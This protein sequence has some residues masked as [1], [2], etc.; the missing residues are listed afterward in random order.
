MDSLTLLEQARS[1]GLV[2]MVRNDKLVVRGPRQ[3]GAL[4]EQLLSHKTEV[5]NALALEALRPADLP[6]DWPFLWDDR[7]AIMEFDGGLHREQA[8]ALALRDIL[9]QMERAGID[10]SQYR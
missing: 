2:V 6:A 8:E 7:A 9:G 10:I 1:A 3:L 5:L 4:A